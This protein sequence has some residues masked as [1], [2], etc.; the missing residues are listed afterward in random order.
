MHWK[1]LVF[2]PGGSSGA[3]AVKAAARRSLAYEA[4]AEEQRLLSQ[5]DRALRPD[6]RLLVPQALP[7]IDH[8]ASA[9][10]IRQNTEAFEL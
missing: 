5:V 2:N 7:L 4:G 6:S 1:V 10:K 9:A 8:R 3:L